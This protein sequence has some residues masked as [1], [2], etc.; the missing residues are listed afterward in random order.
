MEGFLWQFV[1]GEGLPCMVADLQL[2][3]HHRQTA[4]GAG[5]L[6]DSGSWLSALEHLHGTLTTGPSS[7]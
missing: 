3:E 7:P 6:N 1:G 2:R 5:G 4:R